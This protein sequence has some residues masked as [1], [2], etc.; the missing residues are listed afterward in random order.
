MTK[1]DLLIQS[2]QSNDFVPDPE[3]STEL[4]EIL[5]YF[6]VVESLTSVTYAPLVRW[7]P[8]YRVPELK[9]FVDR[10][11]CE[12]GKHGQVL[13][14]YLEKHNCPILVKPEETLGIKYWLEVMFII[15]ISWVF[16]F[17]SIGSYSVVGAVNESMTSAGYWALMQK[18][19]NHP[20]LLEI[21]HAIQKEEVDHLNTYSRAAEKFLPTQW[22]RSLSKMFL[23]LFLNPIGS[24]HGDVAKLVRHLLADGTDKG[25]YSRFKKNLDDVNNVVDTVKDRMV[26]L[27]Q[28][29]Q[30]S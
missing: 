9:K 3:L 12:E 26:G 15:G 10:W 30:Y 1:V 28:G 29:I 23:P 7:L 14:L 21:I 25:F 22:Q 8:A 20:L 11:D 27:I 6:M 19:K 5:Q 4:I 24:K 2:M 13:K 17:I 18:I 16:W